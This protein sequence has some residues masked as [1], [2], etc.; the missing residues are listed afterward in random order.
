MFRRLTALGIL[1]VIVVIESI[2][3][4]AKATTLQEWSENYA[5]NAQCASKEMVDGRMDTSAPISY[6]NDV[7]VVL[8]EKKGIDRILIYNKDLKYFKVLAEEKGKWRPI[9]VF[10]GNRDKMVEIK[11]NLLS[12]KIM[13]QIWGKAKP[14]EIQ[15]I[16]L[17]E[18]F[19]HEENIPKDETEKEK[20][21]SGVG[22]QLSLL[23]FSTP[24][25]LSLRNWKGN[26][27][28]DLKIHIFGLLNESGGLSKAQ[29]VSGLALRPALLTRYIKRTKVFYPYIAAGGIFGFYEGSEYYP[30]YHETKEPIFGT[31]VALG[32]AINIEPVEISF[33]L[34]RWGWI[35]SKEEE[36]SGFFP[37]GILLFNIHLF[38][39]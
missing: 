35:A 28:L 11:T 6:G 9:Q 5:L 1:L 27:G 22:T 4:E 13:V 36:F 14:G 26:K 16:E 29:N 7:L 23:S 24:S 19:K 10:R 17:Y 3:P 25:G 31:E 32:L 12:D 34:I 21:V 38:L 2:E 39:Q 30:E 18:V 15:E 33:D 8:P 37:A 20:V